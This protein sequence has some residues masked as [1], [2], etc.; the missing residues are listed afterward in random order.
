[1]FYLVAFAYLFGV[2]VSIYL[3]TH[4]TPVPKDNAP[5]GQCEAFQYGDM[6]V[7]ETCRT[8]WYIAKSYAPPC[9]G[10]GT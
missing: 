3:G 8:S 9:L 2:A 1:M 10:D 7:C 6:M 5:R 4:T